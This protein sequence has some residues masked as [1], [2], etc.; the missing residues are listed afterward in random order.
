[1][2][3][4]DKDIFKCLQKLFSCESLLRKHNESIFQQNEGPHQKR[5]RRYPGKER[6]QH[7][8]DVKGILGVTGKE[9][10]KHQQCSRPGERES[11]AEDSPEGK[12]YETM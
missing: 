10:G 2:D 11:R 6:I 8:R 3:E 12:I 9:N 5:A 1:M 7:R 4:Y